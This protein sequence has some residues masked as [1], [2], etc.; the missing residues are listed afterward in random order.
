MTLHLLTIAMGMASALLAFAFGFPQWFRVRR[1]GSV[2]GI[3]LPGVA[4]TLVSTAGWLGY[5]LVIKDVWV[6][7]TTLVGIPA[8]MADRKSTRLNS[9]H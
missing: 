2:A 7:T 4:N 3:S 6:L 9:S 8:T 1:T 5:G